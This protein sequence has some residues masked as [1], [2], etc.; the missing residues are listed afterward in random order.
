[1]SFLYRRGDGVFALLEVLLGPDAAFALPDG[2]AW[3]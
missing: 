2:H 3:P 1:M